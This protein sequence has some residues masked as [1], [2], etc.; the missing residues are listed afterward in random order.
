MALKSQTPTARPEHLQ[1]K[2]LW[3]LDPG[4]AGGKKSE[5]CVLK[6][7]GICAH[8]HTVLCPLLLQALMNAELV[9]STGV[10]GSK[11]SC[12]KMALCQKCHFS[13]ISLPFSLNEKIQKEIK[14]MCYFTVIWNFL[15]LIFKTSSSSH[16]LLVYHLQL[17]KQIFVILQNMQVRVTSLSI[18][19]TWKDVQKSRWNPVHFFFS[20]S[21]FQRA[22]PPL[23]A[24]GW[25]CFG[26]LFQEA[27]PFLMATIGS[28]ELMQDKGKH[29]ALLVLDLLSPSQPASLALGDFGL[30]S[31]TSLVLSFPKNTPLTQAI[32][33]QMKS[34]TVEK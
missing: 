9:S 3:D 26:V 34:V 27:R 22:W 12:W 20:M 30:G 25:L 29:K 32:K 7:Q 17:K 1:W 21:H 33:W 13:S 16:L 5:E 6:I 18:S 11:R 28:P 23:S 24:A 31:A 10:S 8:Q 4:D 19:F 14:P 15:L 2:L